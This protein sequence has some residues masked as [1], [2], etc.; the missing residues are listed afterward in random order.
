MIK[1]IWFF[2]GSFVVF[3]IQ[4]HV[5]LA[6]EIAL[7]RLTFPA[8]VIPT[9]KEPGPFYT[10]APETLP[11]R[12]FYI[13]SRYIYSDFQTYWGLELD[14]FE[15]RNDPLSGDNHVDFTNHIL[16]MAFA[17]GIT[18]HLLVGA[19][20]PWKKVSFERRWDGSEVV[21]P[22]GFNDGN[23]G[24]GDAVISARYKILEELEE[25]P[26]S[27]AVGLDIKLPTGDDRR[28]RV[29]GRGIG[30]GETDY[31]VSTMLSRNIRGIPVYFNAGYNREGRD[32]RLDTLEYN[33]AVVF[34]VP[35]N[36]AVTVE[37]LGV[38]F[39]NWE[40]EFDFGGVV[41]TEIMNTYDIGLGVKYRAKGITFECGVT[42]PLNDDF[43][44]TRLQPAIGASYVF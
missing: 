1:R 30:T 31:K 20:L 11:K 38:S 4:T 26:F 5:V 40:T 25:K 39:V 35:K 15:Q 8:L 22:G 3:V 44:R 12:D 6:Q 33:L 37:F 7:P 32:K 36:F 24:I 17:Y 13:G 41:D 29:A 43:T 23:E 42:Y 27:W 2:V 34:L 28:I 10:G 21:E 16:Q 14:D 18:D 19:M 9:E